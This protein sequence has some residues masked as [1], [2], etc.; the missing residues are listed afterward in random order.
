MGARLRGIGISP[1]LARN[2]A[3]IELAGELP[4]AVISKLLGFSIK[5]ALAWNIEA[6]I[7]NPR[8]AAAVAR[9]GRQSTHVRDEWSTGQARESNRLE[10]NGSTIDAGCSGSGGR[11]SLSSGCHVSS[12]RPNEFRVRTEVRR[13]VARWLQRHLSLG[14]ESNTC[15]EF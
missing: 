6:G 15:Y 2:T 14:V 4:A 7:A 10:E 3:L 1:Q 11:A 8:Y 13:R 12:L 5:R 9:S